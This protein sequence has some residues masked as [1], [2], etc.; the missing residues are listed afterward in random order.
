MVRLAKKMCYPGDVIASA[1]RTYFTL[2][3]YRKTAA[4]YGVSKSSVDM[5]VHRLGKLIRPKG[6]QKRSRIAYVVERIKDTVRTLLQHNPFLTAGEI[7]RECMASPSTVLRAIR[8]NNLTHKKV[9]THYIPNPHDIREKQVAFVSR[10][11]GI[12]PHDILSVDETSFSNHMAPLKGYAP[13][14]QR[15][16]HATALKRARCTATLALSSRGIEAWAVVTGASNKKRFL[17]FADKLIACRQRHILL[18]NISFHHSRE[19]LDRLHQGG[20][21]V[22]FL[23]P[24]SPELQPVENAIYVLKQAYRKHKVLPGAPPCNHT[25][26]SEFLTTKAPEIGV[27]WARFFTW[28]S[29]LQCT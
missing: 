6:A 24:Y 29:R 3:S 28:G 20:K 10:V 9:Y 2:K 17:E 7:A 23:P 5:W 19:V 15:L 11:Q 18:D 1:V 27:E 25:A 4:L 26:V 14:G 21:E 16:V 12:D 22:L 8:L 13:R